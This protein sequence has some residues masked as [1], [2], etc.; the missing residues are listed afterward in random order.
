MRPPPQRGGGSAWAP[1][2][3]QAGARTRVDETNGSTRC[4]SLRRKSCAA[5]FSPVQPQAWWARA[6]GVRPSR[7]PGPSPSPQ[8]PSSPASRRARVG[9]PTL[10]RSAC[11]RRDKGAP[12][13]S[14]RAAASCSRTWPTQTAAPST[15]CPSTTTARRRARAWRARPVSSWS[16]LT[17]ASWRRS[18]TRRTSW[19]SSR[20]RMRRRPSCRCARARC[21]PS[22]GGSRCRR[23]TPSSSLRAPGRVRSPSSMRRASSRSACSASPAIHAA[24]W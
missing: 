7:R 8:R 11:P 15:R 17:D 20:A 10:C 1:R 9:A 6:G 12:S 2:V 5:S 23:T 3:T 14:R 19:C 18:R 24:C 21:P 13:C 16:C 4:R 22:H